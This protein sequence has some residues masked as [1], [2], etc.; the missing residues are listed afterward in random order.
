MPGQRAAGQVQSSLFSILLGAVRY[1]S[2][3]GA[4]RIAFEYRKIARQGP[5]PKG[6]QEGGSVPTLSEAA[7]VVIGLYAAKWKPGSRSA[8][9]WRQSLGDYAFPVL[10]S[11]GVD[12][13]TTADVMR[14]LTPIWVIKPTTGKRVR[15]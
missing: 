5:D 13:I 4:R 1:T 14:V 8:D 15:Q 7:E 2:L 10:G 12:R 3:A 6:D 11:K 9:Q